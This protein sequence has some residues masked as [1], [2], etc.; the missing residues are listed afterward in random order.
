MDL[1]GLTQDEVVKRQKE[2]GKNELFTEKKVSFIMKVLSVFREPMFILLF[3]TATIYF[4]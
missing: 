1:K 4:R 2:Y 3:V